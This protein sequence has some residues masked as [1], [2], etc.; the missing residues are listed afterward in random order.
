MCDTMGKIG[1]ERSF[2]AKNSDRSPNEIQIPEYHAAKQGLT[3]TVDCTYISIPQAEETFAVLLSRPAWM[4]GAEMGI[5]E[6]G[7]CIGNEAVFTKGAYGKTGLTGMDMVRLALERSK[8]AEQAL[9]LL[10]SLLETYGQGGNC[11]FDH[12]FYY[13]NAFLIMDRENLYV[14]ETAGKQW[15]YKRFPSANISNRLSIGADGDAYSGGRAFDFRKR[16]TE[17]V[18]TT[19]SGSAKR[20]RQLRSCLPHAD[21]LSGC[22]NALSR[23]DCH[24]KNPFAK[25]TVSS[26]CMHYGGLVGDHTTASMVVS[27]EQSR[28]VVWSTGNSLPCVSLFKPW[29][30]GTQAVLPVVAE[31]SRDGEAYWLEAEIF[32]RQ[33]LGKQLSQEYHAERNAIQQRWISTSEEISDADFPA[34]SRACLDE[35]RAFFEKWKNYPLEACGCAPGFSGRWAKKN[36]ILRDSVR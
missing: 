20:S 6:F 22:M 29:L 36:R 16:Y 19:F 17:P 8:T 23:H 13:D 34:F 3:G 24:V 26:A 25:G 7:L 9:A 31:G 33:L 21:S 10:I 12:D 27:L 18:Y 15:V 35:E 14:L 11:G 4:W 32:R 2:F 5:N 1:R 28:T 30:F